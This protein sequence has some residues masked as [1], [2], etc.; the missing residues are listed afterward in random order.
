MGVIAGHDPADDFAAGPGQKERR[1]AVLIKRV[2]AAEKLFA[3]DHERRHP[4]RVIL[5][6]SPRKLDEGVPL[7]G[8]FDLGDF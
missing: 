4:G 2:F 7:R 6:N 1:V 3:F 5:V 8:G